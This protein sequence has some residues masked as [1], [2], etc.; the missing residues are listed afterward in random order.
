MMLGV[1]LQLLDKLVLSSFAM[2]KLI[3]NVWRGR[4]KIAK[5]R[6]EG[7]VDK[8]IKKISGLRLGA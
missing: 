7:V 4:N 1:I 6:V 2:S 5:I 3:R 8:Y